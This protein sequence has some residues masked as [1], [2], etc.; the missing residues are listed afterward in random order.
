MQEYFFENEYMHS[1]GFFYNYNKLLCRKWVR[2]E[3]YL[4]IQYTID[5]KVE[6]Q[7]KLGAN[8]CKTINWLRNL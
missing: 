8:K 5:K 6:E 3:D 4:D 2:I 1:C 7:G